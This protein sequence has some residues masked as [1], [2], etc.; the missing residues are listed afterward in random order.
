VGHH[1]RSRVKLTSLPHPPPSPEALTLLLRFTVG[2]KIVQGSGKRR[3][4]IA[5]RCRVGVNEKSST[6]EEANRLF[7]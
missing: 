7:K 6:A 5:K 4:R 3:E 2:T 1:R